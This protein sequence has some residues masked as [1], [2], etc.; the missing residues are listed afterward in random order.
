MSDTRSEKFN[1]ALAKKKKKKRQEPPEV[2]EAAL[3]K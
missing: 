2:A 3:S 1:K